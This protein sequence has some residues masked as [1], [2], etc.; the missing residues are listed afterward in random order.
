MLETTYKIA[1][2]L[3][4]KV[5]AVTAKNLYRYFG[6]AEAI[7]NNSAN[8]L[9]KVPGIGRSIA[10]S[11]KDPKVLDRAER[12]YQACIDHELTII[13]FDDVQY[14]NRLGRNHD[15]PFLLYT[16]KHI[17]L[18][19]QRTLA[20]IGTRKPSK[21]GIS[22]CEE[23][24]DHLKLYRP[25]ILSG[26]AYGVDICAHNRAL[27]NGLATWGVIAHGH[28]HIYPNS[29]K[30]I[31]HKMIQT[32]NSGLI[33]EYGFFTRAEREFF[34]MRNRIVAGLCDAV[35]VIETPKRGGSMI[36]AH[37]A[38]QYDKE[39]FAV[40]GRI[41]DRLSQGCNHLIKTHKAQLLEQVEDI[42][43]IMGWDNPSQGSG[44]QQ[45]LF[46]DLSQEEKIIVDLLRKES[47]LHIDQIAML[48]KQNSSSLAAHLLTLEFKGI[49][50]S[51]PGNRFSLFKH[52]K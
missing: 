52:P 46:T 17:D 21:A 45:E 2:T 4:P 31:A 23:L 30:K 29:H 34:P 10:T 40:P 42:A 1:L 49:V 51:L 50:K 24:V 36:T 12:T 35:V 15:C 8:A 5:G 44:I 37:L 13:G 18:N 47:A 14:P 25:I 39:V 16:T 43:Y 48:H 7:F 32:T 22:I 11:L 9:A 20:I 26:M 3:T 33:S 28:Q 27:T 6:S 19:A 38:N 41:Q